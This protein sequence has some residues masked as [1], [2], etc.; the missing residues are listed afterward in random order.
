MSNVKL[1]GKVQRNLYYCLSLYCGL[2]AEIENRYPSNGSGVLACLMTFKH[3]HQL[4]QGIL[5]A[6]PSLSPF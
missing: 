6:V 5:Y 1:S 2:A 3:I 4:I